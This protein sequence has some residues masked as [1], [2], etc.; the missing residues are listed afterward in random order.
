MSGRRRFLPI[1]PLNGPVDETGVKYKLKRAPHSPRIGCAAL[2]D[3]QIA[4]KLG[5]QTR[6]SR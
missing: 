4:S 2:Y 1:A 3:D 6:G 5:R